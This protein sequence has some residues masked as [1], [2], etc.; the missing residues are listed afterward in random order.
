MLLKQ[1]NYIHKSN[2]KRHFS[3]SR[4]VSKDIFKV[5]VVG[6]GPAGFYTAHHLLNKAPLSM[7]LNIDILDRL[8]APYGLSRYGVAPDH[9]EVKKCEEY[10][11]DI[12]KNFSESERHRVRFFGNVEVGKDISMDALE[13]K[14]HSIVLSYGCTTADKTLNIP[15]AD[16][17]GVI[18]AR[19]FVSWYNGHPDSY[20]KGS[21]FIPP[22]LDK[23]EDVTII[24]N[25]NVA[26][27][28]ARVLLGDVNKHWSSTDMT[29]AA[30]TMLKKSKVKNVN[31]VARRGFLESA[32]T[33]KEIRELFELSKNQSIR[34]TPLEPDVLNDID[35]SSLGRV[36]KRRYSIIEKYATESK[37]E[38]YTKRKWSLQYLKSPQEFIINQSD[39]NLLDSTI[40]RTN[41]LVQ[42]TLTKAVKVKPTKNLIKIK[43]ELVIL[44]I[45]YKGSSLSGFD[46]V[47]VLFENN[48][49]VNKGGRVL[50]RKSIGR[51]ETNA[52][53]KEGWYTSG[54]IKTG[55]KGVIATT[56][57]DSFDTAEK[58]LEDLSNRIHLRPQSCDGI[59]LSLKEPTIS[60]DAWKKIN[61]TELENGKK[62]GKSREKICDVEEMITIS[63]K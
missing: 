28:V 40:F 50:S 56:M 18:S 30:I 37:D 61:T 41:E 57:M 1:L 55:P 53:F 33:N 26:L 59:L 22:N 39:N 54:W 49:V 23:V 20:R 29:S 15:G 5:A 9:P 17:P 6:S 8:P 52:I 14:Y 48:R 62:L 19:Q 35:V 27:D 51:D 13:Q 45:G 11:N 24:G 10:L 34:C 2:W 47:D 21:Q 63:C 58:I 36:D 46:N 31:I 43:N 60:W 25:G 16:L 12:M 32:F 3:I 42:D 7:S 44:S 38:E 4:Y